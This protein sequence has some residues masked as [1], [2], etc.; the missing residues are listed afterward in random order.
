MLDAATLR[1]LVRRRLT[2]RTLF[3]AGSAGVATALIVGTG[4]VPAL[5]PAEA[6]TIQ[7]RLAEA[8]QA[9]PTLSRDEMLALD[10]HAF[11]G[12]TQAAPA[13]QG[14]P[15]LKILPLARAKFLAGGRFDLR[16]EATGIDPASVELLLHIQGASGLA[17][18]LTGE[19]GSD[20]QESDIP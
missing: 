4:Q 1:D 17:T 3:R 19:P 9:V 8:V 6:A 18:I 16:V 15:R 10:P 11:T 14:G 20:L 7:T 5:T 2:R 13:E 12:R